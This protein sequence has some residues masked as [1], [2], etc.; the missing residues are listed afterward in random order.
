MGV[1]DD[2]PVLHQDHLDVNVEAVR[3]GDICL[4]VMAYEVATEIVLV[5][6]EHSPPQHDMAYDCSAELY[7]WNPPLGKRFFR[8]MPQ[9]G[10]DTLVARVSNLRDLIFGCR[11][12]KVIFKYV[13]AL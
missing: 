10:R 11:W 7:F 3:N 2:H 5:L 8:G 4:H 13:L 12:R 1:N 9:I 6:V